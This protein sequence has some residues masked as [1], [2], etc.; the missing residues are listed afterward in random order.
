MH[1]DKNMKGLASLASP[2]NNSCAYTKV[3][4]GGNI[5]EYFWY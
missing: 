3:I 5:Q 1:K 4:I 2:F